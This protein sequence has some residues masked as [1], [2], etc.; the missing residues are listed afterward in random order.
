[1]KKIAHVRELEVITDLPAQVIKVIEEAVTILDTEYGEDRDVDS[2]YGGY[3]LVL[4]SEAELQRLKELHI[5][6]LTAIFE[7]VDEIPCDDGQ[8]YVSA[9]ILQSS[10][11]GIVLVMPREIFNLKHDS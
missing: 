4:E 3:V 5:D 8:V 1:M 2:G 10:D 9:L 6:L 7:Y 11:F